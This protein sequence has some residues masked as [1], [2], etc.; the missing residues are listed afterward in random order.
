[1][2]MLVKQRTLFEKINE[3]EYPYKDNVICNDITNCKGVSYL[4]ERFNINNSS[5]ECEKFDRKSF[6]VNIVIENTC[7]MNK[8]FFFFFCIY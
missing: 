7:I 4:V 1:M 6:G 2:I 8:N 5:A 3:H